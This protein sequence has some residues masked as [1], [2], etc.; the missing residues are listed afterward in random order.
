LAGSSLS[1]EDFLLRTA[2]SDLP[3]TSSFGVLEM[4]GNVRERL[5]QDDEIQCP[6]SWRSVLDINPGT[7]TWRFNHGKL[8]SER[9]EDP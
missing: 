1:V 7:Y 4:A 6:D 9:I 3:C 5:A 2:G 8:S